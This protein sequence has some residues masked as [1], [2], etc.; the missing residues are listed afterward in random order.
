LTNC[1][2]KSQPHSNI[3]HALPHKLQAGWELC[4][5]ATGAA[6]VQHHQVLLLLLL[7]PLLLLVLLLLPLF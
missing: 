4:A 1:S 5:A 7:G 3:C 2:A 6:A